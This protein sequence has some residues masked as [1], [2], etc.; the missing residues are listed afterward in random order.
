VKGYL[1]QIKKID[2]TKIHGKFVGDDGSIP[3]RGQEGVQ[4]VLDRAYSM[5]DEALAR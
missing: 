1:D 2:A 5:A 3:D 4:L